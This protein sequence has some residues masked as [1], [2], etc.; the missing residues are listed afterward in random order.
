MTHNDYILAAYA[1]AAAV[2]L[3]CIVDTWRLA[4]RART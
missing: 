1:A 2:W 4:K 3:W